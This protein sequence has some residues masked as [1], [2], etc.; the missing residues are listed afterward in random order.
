P[1]SAR[2]CT[3]RDRA[4]ESR[5][6][7]R[8]RTCSCCPSGSRSRRERTRRSP[9]RRPGCRARDASRKNIPVEYRRHMP[10]LE[11]VTSSGLGSLLGV[12]WGVGHT[13]SLVAAGGVLVLLRAEMPAAVA[14]LFELA[15]AVMLIGLGMRAVYLAARQGTAGPVHAH[16]H[17]SRMHVH[18]GAPAHIHIGAWTLARRPLLVGAVH[19]P[20]GSGALTALVLATLPT[21]GARLTYMALFR[22]GSTLGMAALSGLRGWPLARAGHHRA[23][24]RGVSPA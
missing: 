2:R 3:A 13:V 15:V 20:A 21:T 5:S 24:A 17:G 23:L 16:H 19:G 14:D 6:A 11:L 22:I 12:C 9:S 10:V 8:A 1:D 7:Y 18:P 4:A